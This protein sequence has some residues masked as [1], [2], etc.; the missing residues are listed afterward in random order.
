MQVGRKCENIRKKRRKEVL[1]VAAQ[2]GACVSGKEVKE[3][4]KEVLSPVIVAAATDAIV[5]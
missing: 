2:V 5:Q 4:R 3:K 1:L